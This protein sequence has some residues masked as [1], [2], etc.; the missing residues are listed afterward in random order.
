[1]LHKYW[2]FMN[3][4]LGP[5][6]DASFMLPLKNKAWESFIGGK[7]SQ[8]KP[9]PTMVLALACSLVQVGSFNSLQFLATQ[10]S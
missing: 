1:M 4:L 6:L 10:I 7:M 5:L 2:H 9:I 8:I 3:N